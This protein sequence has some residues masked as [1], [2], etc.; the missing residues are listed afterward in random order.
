[1]L[2]NLSQKEIND[3]VHWDV[4]NW[5]RSFAFWEKNS[6]LKPNSKVLVLG[7]REGGMSLI[8]A[9]N[10][11]NVI[12]SDYFDF[13]D[14]TVK[15]HKEYNL[16]AQISYK[17]VDMKN[18]D[19]AAESVD[20]VVFK[21]VLGALHNLPDQKKSFAQI[22]QVLKPGGQLFFAENLSGSKAHQFLRKK[23]VN[24][25]EN[26]RYITDDEVKQ[27][28]SQFKSCVTVSFG[29]IALL[30][31]S[32]KQREILSTFDRVLSKFTPKKWRYILFGVVTK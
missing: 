10:G 16:E 9:K 24:W 20:L 23:Y 5:S 19:L 21:S 30:G 3:V 27:W 15:L 22:Y 2:N 14:T 6:T 26:W 4:R 28:T 25:G 1:M 32:E 7:D 11:H 18:I 13:P 8:F 31:R 29:V 17:R 12:C